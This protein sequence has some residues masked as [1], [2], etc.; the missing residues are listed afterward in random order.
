MNKERF[1][2][3]VTPR[4]RVE[5]EERIRTRNAPPSKAW[6]L[7]VETLQLL[8]RLASDPDSAADALKLLHELQVHQVEL[9]LVHQEIEASHAAL[10]VELGQYKAA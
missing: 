3:A 10:T 7:G 4:L 9:D 1:E 6:P 8:Y 5:A 2:P